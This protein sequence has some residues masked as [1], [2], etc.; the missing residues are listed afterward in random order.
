[1]LIIHVDYFKCTITEKGR[2]KI[3]EE[4]LSRTTEVKEALLILSSVEKQDEVNPENVSKKAVEEVANKILAKFP[5]CLRYTKAQVNFWKDLAW[6]STIQHARDW[7]ALHMG[8]AE[9][10]EGMRA[11]VEKR[12]ADY[13]GIRKKLAGGESPELPWGQSTISCPKCGAKNLPQRFK[14]CGSCGSKL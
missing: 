4:L 10:M 14:F 13:M 3:I 8:S 2:S 1:M 7:L 6:N 5:E 9:A 12:P 11:F